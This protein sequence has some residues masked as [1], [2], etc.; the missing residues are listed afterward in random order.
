MKHFPLTGLL[1]LAL[2]AL[3][4]PVFAEQAA[5]PCALSAQ[6]LKAN[7]SLSFD[8]F[9]QQGALPSSARTL[10]ERKCYGAAARATEHYLAFKPGLSGPEINVL[11]W[12]LGQYTASSGDERGGGK[13]FLA[14]RKSSTAPPESDGFD[15]NTYVLGSWAFLSKDRETLDDALARL[16]KGEG[17][18]N[19]MN[20][21]VLR[22]LSKCFDR[23][24]L[25]AYHSPACEPAPQPD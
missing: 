13:L 12:H 8:A 6:D 25:E 11:T 18:R 5:D 2:A 10:G 3:H 20:T 23:S 22:G 9:D 24:Y 7:L 21:K 1:L 19:R 4:S 16:A 14:A 17:V 15:W